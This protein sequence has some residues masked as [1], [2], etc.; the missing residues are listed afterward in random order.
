MFWPHGQ[1]T[2]MS[3]RIRGYDSLFIRKVEEADQ[4]PAV[5]QLADVCI[6]KNIPVT[7]VAELFGVTRATVYNWM[8]GKTA[9]NPRYLALIP[10]ITTR[11]S[12][13]K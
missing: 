7:E 5:L 13:R 10:K 12:K 8:T 1:L 11:L 2:T 4:K 9:P 3:N 6:E